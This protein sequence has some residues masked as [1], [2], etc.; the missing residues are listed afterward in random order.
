MLNL[1]QAISKSDKASAKQLKVS[2]RKNVTQ[3]M[4]DAVLLTKRMK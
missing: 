3:F 1:E 2:Y 4:R